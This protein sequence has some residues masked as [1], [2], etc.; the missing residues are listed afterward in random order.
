MIKLL[1]QYSNLLQLNYNKIE[2]R[3]QLAP[4]ANAVAYIALLLQC[5]GQIAVSIREV[6]LQLNGTTVSVNG[7]VNKT[8]LIVD[9]GQVTMDHS[10]V[11]AQAEGSQIT[12]DSSVMNISE[13]CNC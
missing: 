13:F 6:R 9:A 8:L 2:Q 11:G 4:D 1:I 7:K 5:I 10:M 3:L 12:S